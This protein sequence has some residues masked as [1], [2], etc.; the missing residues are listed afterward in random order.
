MYVYVRRG[1]KGEARCAVCV[2]NADAKMVFPVFLY[3]Q[4]STARKRRE[5]RPSESIVCVCFGPLFEIE[6]DKT[7]DK[8]KEKETDR[9]VHH[10]QT[11]RQHKYRKVLSQKSNKEPL[12]CPGTHHRTTHGQRIITAVWVE[13]WKANTYFC[14]FS[15]TRWHTV[16]HSWTQLDTGTQGHRDSNKGAGIRMTQ[17][18]I[19]KY[20]HPSHCNHYPALKFIERLANH[21][22]ATTM[23]LSSDSHLR[24]MQTPGP[25]C[26]ER[27][28]SG[29][30]STF[31]W[32]IEP[33]STCSGS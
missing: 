30:G 19:E 25:C 11:N 12:I 23:P 5:L 2:R 1:D 27:T 6:A 31:A 16:R 29:S 17:G 7:I 8:E 18:F 4:A 22:E 15:W 13:I 24:L 33:P 20:M 32:S 10:K 9:H 3:F 26:S 28:P 21:Y 14:L